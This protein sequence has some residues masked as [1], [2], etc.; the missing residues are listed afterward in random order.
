MAL[1]FEASVDVRVLGVA[2]TFVVEVV[3]ALGKVGTRLVGSIGSPN[4]IGVPP[5]RRRPDSCHNIDLR[6]LPPPVPLHLDDF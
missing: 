6:H 4:V 2:S 5:N 1:G 3:A